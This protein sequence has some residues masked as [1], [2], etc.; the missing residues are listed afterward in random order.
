MRRERRSHR[1]RGR[2]LGSADP[3]SGDT[4]QKPRPAADLD[5]VSRVEAWGKYEAAG[6]GSG[7]SLPRLYCTLPCPWT[8]LGHLFSLLEREITGEDLSRDWVAVWGLVSPSS[9]ATSVAS[10]TGLAR[11]WSLGPGFRRLCFP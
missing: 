1:F 7:A 3:V 9:G 6:S 4:T 11:V 8:V 2:G 10:R 5:V